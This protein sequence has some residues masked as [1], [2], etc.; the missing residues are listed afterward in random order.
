MKDPDGRAPSERPGW[1]VLG[2]PL[3]LALTTAAYAGLV[4]AGF[5]WDD[6]AL[7]VNN[8]HLVGVAELPRYFGAD[9]WA[10]ATDGAETSGYYRPLMLVS[11]W[12]DHALY[13]VWAAGYH[14]TGLVWHLAAVVALH[15]LLSRAGDGRLDPR[16]ALAGA[17]IFALHPV[18]SESVA[19]VAARNDPMAAA[20]G[21]AALA[22][23]LPRDA[24]L[25][26]LA[27]GFTLAVASGFAKESVVL[28]PPALVLLDLGG[29]RLGPWRRAGALLAGVGVVL[30]CRALAGV[31]AVPFP[32]AAQWGLAWTKLPAV[33]GTLGSVVEW[34]WP[35]SGARA[36]EWLE[37]DSWRVGLAAAA[38]VAFAVAATRSRHRRLAW[39]GIGLAALTLAPTALP[40]VS[41]GLLGDRYLYLPMAGLALAAA[42]TVGPRLLPAVGVLAVPALALLFLR[43]P[44]W[45]GERAMWMAAHRDTPSPYTSSGL[46]HALNR[47]GRREE[48]LALFIGAVDA[49]MGYLAACPKIID[50]ATALGEPDEAARLGLWA[51]DAGCAASAE[52]AGALALALARTGDWAEARATLDAAPGPDPRGQGAV[53]RGALL[54]IDGDEDGWR[55]MLSTWSGERA[56]E[57]QVAALL[58][59]AEA[60]QEAP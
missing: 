7:V 54:R 25:R 32:E 17:A 21:L 42:A 45:A 4:N 29:G 14:L 60:G 19:W 55:E 28:L 16:A 43:L 51:R 15:R 23:V 38:A 40:I 39:A 22:V 34:P 3:L 41:K 46:G 11:L 57:P 26:R 18:Q 56:I 8:R 27:A 12:V 36:L 50:V 6:N 49:P 5:V 44:D 59:H 52:H 2:L 53:V 31:G 48:A 20:L 47:E 58:S 1:L 37:V 33:L 24:S 30:A 35:L 9:L 10:I 13:G